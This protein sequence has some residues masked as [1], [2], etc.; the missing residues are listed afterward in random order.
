MLS[1]R[2]VEWTTE[3]HFQIK[4][5]ADGSRISLQDHVFRA[6]RAAAHVRCTGSEMRFKNA[7]R[8]RSGGHVRKP[9]NV[10]RPLRLQLFAVKPFAGRPRERGPRKAESDDG[11]RP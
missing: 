3:S 11:V 6:I 1:I 7:H 9:G 5:L 4:D 2:V 10:L 8:G